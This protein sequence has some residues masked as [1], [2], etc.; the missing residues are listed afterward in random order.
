MLRGN[1]GLSGPGEDLRNLLDEPP[2]SLAGDQ[3]L[4][5]FEVGGDAIPVNGSPAIGETLPRPKGLGLLRDL[6]RCQEQI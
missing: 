5:A 4:R 2:T 3:A 6:P 1:K